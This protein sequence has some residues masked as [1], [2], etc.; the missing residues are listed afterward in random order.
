MDRTFRNLEIYRKAAS[1]SNPLLSGSRRESSKF[2]TTDMV[3][4]SRTDRKVV[5]A[6]R[7]QRELEFIRQKSGRDRLGRARARARASP[8]RLAYGA[9]SRRRAGQRRNCRQ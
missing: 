8:A 3:A 4:P 5:G 2:T 9:G 7:G 1:P 6:G